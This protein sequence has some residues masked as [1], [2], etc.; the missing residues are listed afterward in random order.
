MYYRNHSKQLKQFSHHK[1]SK[2]SEHQKKV[3]VSDALERSCLEKKII[4]KY[5]QYKLNT[6]VEYQLLESS[7]LVT[8]C[9]KSYIN[10]SNTN[11]S[12]NINTWWE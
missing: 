11:N 1:T 6:N 10:V 5:D 2:W 7:K 8:K 4:A 12:K 9:N 3:S